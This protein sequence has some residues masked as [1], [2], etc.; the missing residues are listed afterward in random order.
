[1]N[2]RGIL[3]CHH[4]LGRW[5]RTLR[6]RVGWDFW[7]SAHDARSIIE[8]R[9]GGSSTHVRRAAVSITGGFYSLLRSLLPLPGNIDLSPFLKFGWTPSD[10]VCVRNLKDPTAK[11]NRRLRAAGGRLVSSPKFLDAASSIRNHW[12]KLPSQIRPLIPLAR[13]FKSRSAGE[14]NLKPAP[15]QMRAAAL[16]QRRA[17]D[18]L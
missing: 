3:L 5:I 1:M 13:S 14:L 10:V 16:L 11:I 17:R 2:P 6:L 15:S 4:E 18:S 7:P 8:D 9:I 12:E